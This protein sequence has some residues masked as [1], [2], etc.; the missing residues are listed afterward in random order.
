M[1]PSTRRLLA[2]QTAWQTLE[3]RLSDCSAVKKF[4]T[5]D[6]DEANALAHSLADLEES[7]ERYTRELLP[8]LLASGA[9]QDSVTDV[10]AEIAEELRHVLYHVQDPKFFRHLTDT[11]GSE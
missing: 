4:S 5:S 3:R 9:D 1:A 7:F 2:D 10:L 6:W 8:R 11:S